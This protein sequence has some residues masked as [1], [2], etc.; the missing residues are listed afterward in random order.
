MPGRLADPL[1]ELHKPDGS[2]VTND[3]WRAAPNASEIPN[4]LLPSDDRESV[5]LT[6]LAP[7]GYTVIVKGAHGETGV[8]LFEAFV[9]DQASPAKL[10]NIST[11]GFGKRT[12]TS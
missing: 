11:R 4:N 5:I 1:I 12:I 8:G 3:N 7:G 2:T 6:T 10:A 9:Q